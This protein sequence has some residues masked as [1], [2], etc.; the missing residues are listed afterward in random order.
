MA[1]SST[2]RVAVI[3]RA[4]DAEGATGLAKHWARGEG[5]RIRTVA[6]CRRREDMRTWDVGPVWEVV[7]V[8]V[9]S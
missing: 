8:V 3:F 7:L 9:R 6:S 4:P 2:D 5:L 1:V